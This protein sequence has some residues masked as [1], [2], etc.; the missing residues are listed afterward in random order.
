MNKLS[1]K[2]IIANNDIY[3]GKD[4]ITHAVFKD[5]YSNTNGHVALGL[6][7]CA[8]LPSLDEAVDFANRLNGSR[9]FVEYSPIMTYYEDGVGDDEAAWCLDLL[10]STTYRASE[11]A[12]LSLYSHRQ[13]TSRA[14]E[15]IVELKDLGN[16]YGYPPRRIAI[17]EQV[18]I[19]GI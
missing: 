15:S 14:L 19:Y 3:C 17:K 16:A 1:N 9:A 8:L 11:V 13:K 6:G 18:G 10:R 2:F 4:D 7:V 5:T 12:I